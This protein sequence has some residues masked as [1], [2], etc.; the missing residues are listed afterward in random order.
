M[1]AFAQYV[2]HV[3][4]HEQIAGRGA[5]EARQIVGRAG[6]EAV[7]E[8]HGGADDLRA[9]AVGGIDAC[10]QFRIDRDAAIAREFEEARGIPARLAGE[11]VRD[12]GLAATLRRQGPGHGKIRQQCRIVLRIE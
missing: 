12:F 7:T 6:D 4:E 8:A 5:G 10:R 9:G 3:A 1:N 2:A 11:R